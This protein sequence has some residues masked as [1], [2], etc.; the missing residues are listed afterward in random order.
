VNKLKITRLDWGKGGG[1]VGVDEGPTRWREECRC[2]RQW[3]EQIGWAGC[4]RN[5]SWSYFF[6]AS[7][8]MLTVYARG[9]LRWPVVL[10]IIPVRSGYALAVGSLERSELPSHGPPPQFEMA[11]DIGILACV[12]VVIV[13]RRVCLVVGSEKK[14]VYALSY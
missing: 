14:L 7:A 13:R 11:N 3:T 10:A 9:R 4:I 8:A 12:A 6:I 2:L 1:G 5:L